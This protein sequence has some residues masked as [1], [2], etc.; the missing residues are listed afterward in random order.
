MEI[1]QN[2][3]RLVPYWRNGHVELAKRALTLGQFT[4]AHA[5]VLAAKQ[6]SKN[7][8]AQI[9]LIHAQILHRSG[10]DKNALQILERLHADNPKDFVVLEE[11]ALLHNA[12][13]EFELA[14]KYL[15]AIPVKNRGPEA[16]TALEYLKKKIQN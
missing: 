4:L 16:Q 14:L 6:L 10:A 5:C 3:L 1:L 15:M 12:R 9:D 7:N 13:A 11:L 2:H 8:S